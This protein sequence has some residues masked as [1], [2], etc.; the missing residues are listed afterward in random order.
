[1]ESSLPKKQEI[2]IRNA[3]PSEFE[4]IGRLLVQV[5]GQ[6]EGFP[7]ADEQPEYYQ[8]LANIGALTDKPDIELLVAL[9]IDEQ[10]LGAVVY[11]SAMHAYGVN[12]MV[13]QEKNVSAFRLLGV[14]PTS[15]GQGV[16]KKL[17][18]ECIT[19]AR[20]LNHRQVII[21]S[22][23]AMKIAWKMYEKIG[24]QRS[25]DLDFMQGELPVFGFRLVL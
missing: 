15:R 24:F 5:Y 3:R 17:I 4:E 6:L 18:Q 25:A 13:V 19:K 2:I 8:M 11:I 12:G 22:T 23:S 10:I 21:H 7:T 20:I 14:S 1:M 9:S 16:G